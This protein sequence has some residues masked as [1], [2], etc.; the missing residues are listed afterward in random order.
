MKYRLAEGAADYTLC[1]E[2]IAEE[3]FPEGPIDFPTVMALDDDG[4]LVGLLAT[5]PHTEMVLA[6]P[7][8]LRHD[9]RRPMTAIKLINLYELTMRGLGIESVIF[10]AV[11]DGFLTQGIDRYF[12][13]I[14]PYAEDGEDQ[15]FIW[16]LRKHDGEGREST[17][18]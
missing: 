1:A 7:L 17:R 14:R 8:V 16:P 6:G 9:R 5:T 18:A 3:G 11:K 4:E 10:H 13:N 12:P 15:F 2:L